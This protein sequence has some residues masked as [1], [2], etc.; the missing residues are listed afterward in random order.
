[1]FWRQL[2]LTVLL[3]L[4]H[5]LLLELHGSRRVAEEEL[6]MDL[7]AGG[8]QIFRFLLLLKQSLA[9]Q[10][11]LMMHVV[12]DV[13]P[14]SRPCSDRSIQASNLF[15]VLRLGAPQPPLQPLKILQRVLIR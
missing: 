5:L 7:W 4:N 8:G 2:L 11:L 12:H 15:D 6:A 1:M 14:L 13:L 9:A 10:A 3:F